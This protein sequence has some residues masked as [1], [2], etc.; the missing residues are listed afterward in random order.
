MG[1]Q[2]KR[3][4]HHIHDGTL[5]LMYQCVRFWHT[6]GEIATVWL[7]I[8]GVNVS[9][10]VSIKVRI[11]LQKRFLL[12]HFWVFLSICVK[13]SFS[14]FRAPKTIF[15]LSHVTHHTVADKWS[16]E[17]VLTIY[18]QPVGWLTVCVKGDVGTPDETQLRVII[19]LEESVSV[20]SQTDRMGGKTT[21]LTPL[22]GDF[23][24]D[25]SWNKHLRAQIALYFVL[26]DF[27]TLH[28]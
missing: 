6:W 15:E 11:Y 3:V 19:R 1:F 5:D 28:F 14:L 27:I 13:R 20:L 23:R 12:A 2:L 21:E 16:L 8:E 10:P 24:A 26:N 7:V 22:T 4:W 25:S 17:Y 9:F 18:L